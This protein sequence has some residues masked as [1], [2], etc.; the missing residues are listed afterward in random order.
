MR[1]I[2]A[3]SVG[4]T[5]ALLLFLSPSGSAQGAKLNTGQ[6]IFR[7]DTF[8]DEQLWTDALGLH[9]A[10]QS[11]SP[12]AAL[13]VG[14]KVDGDALLPPIVRALQ[15]GQLDID[16]PAVT[17]QLLKLNAVVGVMAKV[18]DGRVRSLGI[19]CALCHSTVDD[20]VAEGIGHRL[21]GWPNLDLNV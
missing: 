6:E 16:D 13:S 7:Y 8:G 10:I 3:A 2:G 12:K 11:V 15:R 17:L 14:L 18:T 4:L 1:L 20:S 9:E 21:D 5:L 19:T